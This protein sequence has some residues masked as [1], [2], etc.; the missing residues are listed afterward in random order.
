MKYNLGNISAL[1]RRKKRRK[2][3]KK[4]HKKQK[5]EQTKLTLPENWTRVNRSDDSNAHC[6]TIDSDTIRDGFIYIIIPNSVNEDYERE[7]NDWYLEQL[8]IKI[9]YFF[10]T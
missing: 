6:Y 10:F 8:E 3:K 7:A 2:K 1:Q 9:L 5:K 4:T